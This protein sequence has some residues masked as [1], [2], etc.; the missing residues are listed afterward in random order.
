MT[1]PITT[2]PQ[3]VALRQLPDGDDG[4]DLAEHLGLQRDAVRRSEN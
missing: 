3:G 1:M 4:R 2:H